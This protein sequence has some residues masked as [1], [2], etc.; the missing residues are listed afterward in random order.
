MI[1]RIVTFNVISY[2]YFLYCLSSFCFYRGMFSFL[3]IMSDS[4]TKR[5]MPV[6]DLD[7]MNIRDYEIHKGYGEICAYYELNLCKVC[8]SKRSWMPSALKRNGW[9][10][11][12]A[13][14]LKVERINMVFI[15]LCFFCQACSI[16]WLIKSS[17]LDL[18]V[19]KEIF[20]IVGIQS[21]KLD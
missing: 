8:N 20:D 9:T 2:R 11:S 19:F 10:I 4:E 1:Q 21:V 3:L 5:G 7:C 17:N 18:W 14:F 16:Y 12:T 15:L 6:L 13:Q